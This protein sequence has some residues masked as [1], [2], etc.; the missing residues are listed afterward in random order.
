MNLKNILILALCLCATFLT[1]QS[2]FEIAKDYL[3]QTGK[4]TSADLSDI[5]ISDEYTSRHNGITHLY[6]KQQYQGVE[7]LNSITNFNIK[8]GNISSNGGKFVSN[9]DQKINTN[10]AGISPALALQQVKV[11]HEIE[12]ENLSIVSSS[13]T[14]DRATVFEKGNI[15]LENITV[16]LVYVEK[17]ELLRLCWEVSLYEKSAENWWISYVDAQTNELIE[18]YNQVIHCVFHTEK[19]HKTAKA[20]IKH[21]AEITLKRNAIVVANSYNV[22]AYPVESP[23]HGNRTIQI[24]PW[25]VAGDAGTLGWHDDGSTTY[26]VTKG[27]NADAYQDQNNS[28]GPT[29]GNAARADG[30]ANLEFDFPLD[31]SQEPLDDPDPYITN[32][33][34]WNNLMHDIWY[35]YGFDEVSGNFQEDN[36]GRGGDDSDYVRAEAQDGG[37]TNNANFSTPVDGSNP[38][39]QM[40]LWD[41]ASSIEVNA[42]ASVAGFYEMAPA[43]FGGSLNNPITG[44]VVEADDGSANPSLACNALVN[45][46]EI[47]GNIALIDRGTCEFGTKCLNAQN[48]GAIAVLVCNNVSGLVT[49]GPGDDGSQVTIPAVMIRQSDCT[50]IRAE[51]NNGLNVTMVESGVDIDGDLDNGIIAHEYGHG[52]SI[53]LTGGP[54]NSGC[55]SNA[56]QMGEGWSDFFGMWMT[57]EGSDEHFDI[58]GVGTYALGESPSG[59]GI[60]PAPYTTDMS[61]NSYTY[62][63]VDDSGISQPHGIGF[64]WCTMIWDLNWALINQYGLDL[65]L[66]NGN[67][68]NNIAA[69][70]VIDGLKGQPCSPGF[71]DGR[72]AILQ[73]DLDNNGEANKNIIWNVFARR[74]LG[75]SASQGSSS[76][77]NDQVE[78]FDLPPGCPL[79]TEEELFGAGPLPVELTAFDAIVNNE[80]QEIELYWSTA[81]EINNKGFDLQRRTDG[82]NDFETI[83]WE[84]SKTENYGNANYFFMDEEVK[85]GIAYYYRL[86]QVD[87]NGNENF[88]DVVQAE[89]RGGVPEI[90]I[91][92]NPTVGISTVQLSETLS[93]QITMQILNAQGQVIGASIFETNGAAA[94]EINLSQQPEGVYFLKFEIDGEQF[95]KRIILKK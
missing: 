56:E 9:L 62:G 89:L 84:D 4:Y 18:E 10:Q 67:G 59:G 40:Y 44:D 15:A 2:S 24:S 92:P 52:I 73:A 5:Q 91:F 64:I 86:R 19:E 23:S 57:I 12:D 1:A 51:L 80:K 3:Q 14:S 50:T 68:G 83:A 41:P 79:M 28:N 39:M 70:L 94:L 22:F 13:N 61:I 90:Q 43:G 31:L 35:Q 21:Q 71:V 65:N 81:L 87:H 54:S 34:Y 63:N 82:N 11:L 85:S 45:G 77:R 47:S 76:S 95:V 32:L 49:M 46:G 7:I 78:A 55:L 42:P 36:L 72:D 30:G 26:T 38:R 27:N 60:R 20:N 37:G 74:G 53:R 58:R 16:R 93:G 8:S 29:G 88:S 33:F 6:L 25:E 17:E 66:Y 69:Q 48:A 75:F